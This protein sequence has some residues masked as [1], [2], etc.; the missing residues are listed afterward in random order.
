MQ[1]VLSLHRA[2]EALISMASD[3]GMQSHLCLGIGAH[4]LYTAEGHNPTHH[5][6]PPLGYRLTAAV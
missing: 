2:F 5:Q 4:V 6:I 3:H 1:Q